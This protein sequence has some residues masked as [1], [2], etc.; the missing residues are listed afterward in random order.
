M[1]KTLSRQVIALILGGILVMG[2][3]IWAV[4]RSADNGSDAIRFAYQNRI[5]SAACIVA[6]ERSL[7]AEEGLPIQPFRF[8][9]GPACAEALYSG[10]ADIGT[11]GDT[12]ALITVA[13]DDRFVII[14]SHGQGEHRHRLM[15][16]QDGPIET[17]ED[18][19]DKTVGIKKGTS[20]Y[21]GFLLLLAARQL[22]PAEIRIVDMTPAEM[23]DAL[24]AGSID[25]FVAS[26]PTPSLAQMRG[27]RELTTMGGLGNT[28]PILILAR[29][30]LLHDR[31]QDVVRFLRAL[32]RA[33]ETIQS[34]PNETAETLAQ[35][36]GLTPQVAHSAMARHRYALTLDETIVASLRQ[37]ASFL[38]NQGTIASAPDFAHALDAQ[39]LQSLDSYVEEQPRSVYRNRGLTQHARFTRICLSRSQTVQ[40]LDD[41]EAAEDALGPAGTAGLGH[42]HQHHHDQPVAGEA[43]VVQDRPDE[44]VVLALGRVPRDQ[45]TGCVDHPDD[46]GFQQPLPRND[47][48]EHD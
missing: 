44:A 32:Q 14:A 15:V 35:I 28:Y 12:T 3:A 16:A 36:T 39:Y 18:L 26:E 25:A 20:T 46:T 17:V 8:N 47:Q 10:S 43:Q 37:T 34:A 33:E 21:G 5:G 2:L 29:R 27:A 7:F 1:R 48:D 45:V 9:S 19:R 6:V 31:P 13:R 30:D 23:P 38:Q 40:G 4:S 24:A 22:D 11:M 42:D 41:F